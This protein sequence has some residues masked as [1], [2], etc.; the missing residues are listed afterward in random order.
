VSSRFQFYFKD[1]LEIVISIV[2]I[3]VVGK[4]SEV[5]NSEKYRLTTAA[6][7]TTAEPE[8]TF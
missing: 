5:E 8:C 6:E 7:T 3:N 4:Y 1:E 2:E